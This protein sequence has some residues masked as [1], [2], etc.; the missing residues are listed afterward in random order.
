MV[1]S[2]W[3][4]FVRWKMVSPKTKNLALAFLNLRSAR[5]ARAANA[6]HPP[7]F[8]IRFKLPRPALT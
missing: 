6:E 5:N 7:Y 4:L 3:V 1:L 8:K 2:V